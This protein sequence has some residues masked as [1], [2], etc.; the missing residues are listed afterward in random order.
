MNSSRKFTPEELSLLTPWRLPRV[1]DGESDEGLAEAEKAAT[2]VE[3]E[4][5]TA[6]RLTVEDI[7]AMQRQ[8]H[9]EAAALGREEGRAEGYREGYEAGRLEG[10]AHAE[11]EHREQGARLQ[12]ILM[13]LDEPL[14]RVN[15]EVVDE[16][17]ALAVAMARQLVRRELRTDPGQIIAVVREALSALPGSG[18]KVSLHL[19]PDDAE[20]VRHAMSLDENEHSWRLLE[21]PL[22]TRGG[23]QIST[24]NSR[25]DASV[26]KRMAAVV[27]RAF[28]GEREGDL[29]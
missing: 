8:A 13:A 19:H 20:L 1:G 3:E 6:P 21:D 17:G 5:E 15:D 14:S 29:P 28:G 22:L 11:T 23:C 24:E 16:L 4:V 2:V 26:E 9:D 10:L 12:A 25:I 18:R 27:A 7:E